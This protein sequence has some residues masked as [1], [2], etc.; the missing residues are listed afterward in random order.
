MNH[1]NT[2]LNGGYTCDAMPLFSS[3]PDIDGNLSLAEQLTQFSDWFA[4]FVCI[5]TFLCNAFTN[6]L[7]NREDMNDEAV[8][9]AQYCSESLKTRSLALKAA[10]EGVR[11]RYLVEYPARRK[12]KKVSHP[13]ASKSGKSLSSK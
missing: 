11:E 13:S 6:A 1:E 4:E 3:F 12:P 5:N 2:K 10:F 7:I 9:G 8:R